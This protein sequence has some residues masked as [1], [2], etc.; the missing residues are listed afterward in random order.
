MNIYVQL[1]KR[2]AFLRK[3]KK[4]SQLDLALDSGIN[5][6][7]ISDLERGRRNPS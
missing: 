5:K 2:I 4:M 1:G 3:K 7:Y 6:N